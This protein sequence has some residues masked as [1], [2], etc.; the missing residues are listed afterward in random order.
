MKKVIV[1]FLTV[2]FLIG[3]D[4]NASSD[5]KQVRK[6][7]VS[8]VKINKQINDIQ[9]PMGYWEV[10]KSYPQLNEQH[11]QA[12][13][14]N[15]AIKSVVD[16]YSCSGPGDESFNT[17][18]I[19]TTSS[20][21]SFHYEV[22]WMCAQMPSPSY[23]EGGLIYNLKTGEP[24]Q[25]LDEFTSK[26]GQQVFISKVKKTLNQKF[27]VVKQNTGVHCALPDNISQFTVQKGKLI[28]YSPA[29][30]AACAA[31]AKIGISEIKDL[32]KSNSVLLN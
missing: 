13:K 5:L 14:L 4:L 3:C 25:L 23:T 2:F 1:G 6:T 10:N 12:S 7:L 19:Y 31:S 11:S 17:S 24:V 21:L 32:L 26:E 28:A 20:L 30:D 15:K 18:A 9:S 22:M 8:I 16:K 27:E 29:E